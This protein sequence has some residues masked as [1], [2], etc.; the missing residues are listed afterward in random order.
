MKVDIKLIGKKVTAVGILTVLLLVLVIPFLTDN[1]EAELTDQ[2][3]SGLF[4]T[5]E[6]GDQYTYCRKEDSDTDEIIESYGVKGKRSK[7]FD[8]D[9]SSVDIIELSAVLDS[10][11]V[12]ITLELDGPVLYG[13]SLMYEIYFVESTHQHH[14][15]LVDTDKF[16][17]TMLMKFAGEQTIFNI[18]LED[19]DSGNW[20]AYSYPEL[21]SMTGDADDN[22]ITF[23]VSTSDLESVGVTTG[24]GFGLFAVCA[25]HGIGGFGTD[26]LKTEVTWD[27]AG[28]GAATG[29]EE[30]NTDLYGGGKDDDKDDSGFLPGFETVFFVIA[31]LIGMINLNRRRKSK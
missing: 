17:E 26:S 20:Y 24:S 4:Y 21:S 7:T 8:I 18:E 31:L 2:D 14:A 25:L 5:D 30:F 1:G 3:F 11:T 27:T 19:D 13:G 23:T 10:G 28:V 29:P 15:D 22:V 16:I 6:K 9:T 12:T